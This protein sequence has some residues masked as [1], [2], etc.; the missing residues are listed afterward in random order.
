MEETIDADSIIAQMNAQSAFSSKDVEASKNLARRLVSDV[1]GMGYAEALKLILQTSSF[2]GDSGEALKMAPGLARNAQILSLFGKRDAIEQV[3][4][5]IKAGELTGLTDKEGK[6]DVGKLMSFVTGLTNTV[7]SS[8]GTT[9]INK[10]LTSIRQFGAGADAAGTDFLLNVLPA[11]QKIMGE[12]KAGTALQSFQ[13]SLLAARPN[14]QNKAILEEQKRLGIRGADGHLSADDAELLSR[15][16]NAFI[17]SRVLPALYAGGYDTPEKIRGEL[18]KFLPRNTM[19]RLVAA[20]IFDEGVISKEADRNRQQQASGGPLGDKLLAESPQNQVKA[21]MEAFRLMQASFGDAA[22]K[23]LTEGMRALADFFKRMGDWAKEH[24]DG[25]KDALLGLAGAITFLGSAAVLKM[26]GE[27]G[28]SGGKLA[29]LGAGIGIL[30][31]QMDSLPG[32]LIQ[33]ATGAAIGAKVGGAPG[34][35]VGAA[36]F[37]GGGVGSWIDRN[38]PG[39]SAIDDFVARQTGGM[40]GLTYDRQQPKGDGKPIRVEVVNGSDL[41]RGVTDIQTR[42][43]SRPS[44]GTTGGDNRASPDYGLLGVPP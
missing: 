14:T 15:D 32:W 30:A 5:G 19:E 42:Q 27:L 16:T 26:L 17:T 9:D 13:Q 6:I 38:V 23:P 18:P 24:P 10:Y 43:L 22:M 40:I 33:A 44:T 2:T 12:S 29:L 36:A 34:A 4:S 41:A 7:V 37:I 28:G 1:P 8:G 35:A 3:E 25:A 21:F 31:G 20:G 39:A 11:Y